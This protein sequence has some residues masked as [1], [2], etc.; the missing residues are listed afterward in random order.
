[1]RKVMRKADYERLQFVE[2]DDCLRKLAILSGAS[3]F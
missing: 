1:M 2:I 3:E